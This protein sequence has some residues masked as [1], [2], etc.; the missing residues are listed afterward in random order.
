[1]KRLT[2]IPAQITSGIR[3]LAKYFRRF[4]VFISGETEELTAGVRTRLCTLHVELKQEEHWDGRQENLPEVNCQLNKLPHF[5]DKL[6]V[7]DWQLN[8]TGRLEKVL[9]LTSKIASKSLAL[10][11]TIANKHVRNV[12][13][14]RVSLSA[15]RNSSIFTYSYAVQPSVPEDIALR[16]ISSDFYRG[17]IATVVV[18]THDEFG[19]L[20]GDSALVSNFRVNSVKPT[21]PV[22]LLSR[23]VFEFKLKCNTVGLLNTTIECDLT[24][25]QTRSLQFSLD[26]KCPPASARHSSIVAEDLNRLENQT[27]EAGTAVN[28]RVNVRDIYGNTLLKEE[29]QVNITA[30]LDNISLGYS[31]GR[32]INIC[33]MK[34]KARENSSIYDATIIPRKAGIRKLRLFFTDSNFT[35]QNSIKV[36]LKVNPSRLNKIRVETNNKTGNIFVSVPQKLKVLAFD[37]FG[38]TITFHDISRQFQIEITTSKKGFESKS[39][40]KI[41]D[42]VDCSQD[43]SSSSTDITFTTAGYHTLR[44]SLRESTSEYELVATDSITVFVTLA[45]LSHTKSCVKLSRS[46]LQVKAGEQAL[47]VAKVYDVYGNLVSYSDLQIL[48]Q[49]IPLVAAFVTKQIERFDLTS[50]EQR[51][52]CVTS[53]AETGVYEVRCTPLIAGRRTLKILLD[54]KLVSEAPVEVYVD[55]SRL[56]KIQGKFQTKRSGIFVNAPQTLRIQ[57]FDAFGNTIPFNDAR[58]KLDFHSNIRSINN[59]NELDIGGVD[60]IASCSVKFVSAGQHCV[61]LLLRDSTYNVDATDSVSI[62]VEL[63]NRN[64]WDIPD[65]PS[66]EVFDDD[67]HCQLGYYGDTDLDDHTTITCYEVDKG[68]I[69]GPD[70]ARQHNINRV[71]GDEILE[72]DDIEKNG[73]SRATIVRVEDLSVEQALQVHGL[74]LAYLRGRHYRQEASR[75]ADLREEWKVKSQ[76][77]F[78]EGDR[79][80]AQNCK[81][82]KEKY[83]D[84]MNV[85]NRMARDEIFSMYNQGR[86]LSEIDLHELYVGDESKLQDFYNQLLERRS[87]IEAMKVLKID[88][89]F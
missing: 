26:V 28:F 56:C 42:V 48:Q 60:G 76:M 64:L 77:A 46:L 24:S 66:V 44:L 15:N 69:I 3:N 2:Q 68:G 87:D 17:G 59:N 79:R 23:G 9:Y 54:G 19:N 33:S 22:K 13:H 53:Q 75:F 16:S 89:R 83:S 6:E 21:K 14:N 7:T 78:R 39:E 84:L 67:N 47:V 63:S 88:I 11:I 1:M 72:D 10:T 81:R 85:C 65:N 29:R 36:S 37:K 8:N 70:H 32:S 5:S 49:E 62:S 38:N 4:N 12:H 74:L 58:R 82:I 55:P 40:K 43:R 73:F 80:E 25:G 52:I 45:P 50:E 61:R 30:W 18:E 51:S 34:C 86:G 20:S 71:L 41:H 57:A 35:A 31:H 27:F